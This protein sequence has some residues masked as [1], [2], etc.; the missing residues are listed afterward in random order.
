M[1]QHLVSGWVRRPHARREVVVGVIYIDAVW[2]RDETAAVQDAMIVRPLLQ[3]LSPEHR[4][5][6]VHI[7]PCDHTIQATAGILG[8]PT[9]T[10]KSRRHNALRKPRRVVTAEI[11]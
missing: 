5:V 10:A 8:V 9:G 2:G 7:Y 11:A 3:R 4:A 6:L 1:T